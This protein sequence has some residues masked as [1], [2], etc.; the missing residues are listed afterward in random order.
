[1]H[2][3]GWWVDHAAHELHRGDRTFPCSREI[4][5]MAVWADHALLLSSDTDCLSLWDAEGLVRVARVGVYPQ[6]MAVLGDHVAVCGGADGCVHLLELPGLRCIASVHLPGMPER[7][8]LYGS[9]AHVLTLL[10]EP[11]THTVLISANLNTGCCHHRLTLPGIPGTLAADDA[12]LW[13]GVSEQVL[14]LAHDAHEPDMVVKGVDLPER[15]EIQPDGITI[16]DAFKE[17]PFRVCCNPGSK[18]GASTL[19]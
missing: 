13:I 2:D 15:I 10:T 12:G 19:R 9:H 17:Q 8:A 4:E 6:D 5:A 7:I 18:K 3:S 16:V 1:M 11:D 14:H